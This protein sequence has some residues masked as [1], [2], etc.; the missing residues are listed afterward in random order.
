MP[1][2]YQ[3]GEVELLLDACGRSKRGARNRAMIMVLWRTGFRCAEML[4]LDY[5]CDVHREERGI[6]IRTR[7]PKGCNRLKNPARPRAAG[8]GVKA[9]AILDEWLKYRGLEH[10][11]LFVTRTGKRVLTSYLRQLMPELGKRAGIPGEVNHPHA[12]RHTFAAE[13]YL[14]TND[15]IALRDILGHAKFDT[16]E[17]YLRTLGVNRAVSAMREREW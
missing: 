8:L 10:G 16:T 9:T 17:Q 4:S 1:H 12:L 14:E 15:M 11:P 5:P 3:P 7:F 2:R 6:T 13:F